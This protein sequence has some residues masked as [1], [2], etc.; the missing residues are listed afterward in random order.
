MT[1]SDSCLS[2][3]K[4]FE[5][6][7]THAYRCPAGIPT[8]GYGTTTYPDGRKVQMEDTCTEKDA[9]VWLLHEI[10]EDAE[11]INRHVTTALNQ[12]QFDALASFAYNVGR[13]AFMGSTLLWKLNAGDYHG[14]ADQFLKWTHGGG[15]ELPGLVRRRNAER[16]L[17]LAEV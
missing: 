17:F 10:T 4:S 15:V 16:D 12:N 5:G 9:C 14:A 3:V 7:Q 2:L 11:A 8:I 1:P 6:F 13:G